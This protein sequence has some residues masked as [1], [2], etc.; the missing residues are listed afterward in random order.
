MQ[1]TW[2]LKVTE[3][4]RTGVLLASNHGTRQLGAQVSL[5]IRN[6]FTLRHD[7]SRLPIPAQHSLSLNRERR[8]R[9][10]LCR[11]RRA[12]D[13]P[14]CPK[15]TKCTVSAVPEIKKKF[16]PRCIASNLG[17]LAPIVVARLLCRSGT[18]SRRFRP[19]LFLCRVYG[20]LWCL[21]SGA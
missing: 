8:S 21:P 20:R 7:P 3:V 11:S 18:H 17:F 13:S 5:V 19:R 14:E 6:I 10:T 4:H 12:R 15:T 9:G 2:I 1:T 16:R